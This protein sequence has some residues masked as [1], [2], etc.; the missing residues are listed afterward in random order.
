MSVGSIAPL[1]VPTKLVSDVAFISLCHPETIE[2]AS[3]FAVVGKST[4]TKESL[5]P[6]RVAPDEEACDPIVKGGTEIS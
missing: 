3:G 1:S 2:A 5:D 6:N 4:S